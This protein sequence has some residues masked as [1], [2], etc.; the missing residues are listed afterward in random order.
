MA[1]RKDIEIVRVPVWDLPIRLFHWTVVG[2]VAFNVYTGLT[3]GLWQMD[4]HMRSGQAVLA[5]VLF[6]IGWGFAGGHHARFA[7]FV[8]GP[9]AVMAY[10]R[11]EWAGLGHN[12]LGALSVLAML[13][14]MLVLAASGLCA[15]DDIF[16]E[17]PLAAEVGKAWSNRLTVV[18][19]W[20]GNILFGLIGLHLAAVVFYRI[21]GNDLIQ[22]M[23]TGVKDVPAGEAPG[24]RAAPPWWRAPLVLAAAVA[25][26]VGI[27]NL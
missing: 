2:L 25:L 26:V 12:P 13:A 14:A 27:V 21:K 11:G 19:H 23:V 4:W 3:G 9:R 18:H 17:G 7:N 10:I 20:A 24:E 1:E 5:L 22:P 8:P 16:T 15:N 6:R